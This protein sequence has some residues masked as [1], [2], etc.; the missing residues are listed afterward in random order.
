LKSDR[1]EFIKKVGL[2]TAAVAV[3]A[4][5]LEGCTENQKPKKISKVSTTDAMQYDRIV[6]ANDRLRVGVI[7]FSGRFRGS[8]SKAF[9]A[10]SKKLN[11]EFVALSDI[12]N[13]RREDGAAYLTELQGKNVIGYRNNEE[14]YE[15]S[16]TDAVIISTAD[17]QHAYHATEAVL[18][19]RDAYVEKPLAE[20]MADNIMVLNAV[21]E[22]GKIV[23]LGSQRRS[24][25]NYHTAAKY[26]KSGKFGP[27]KVVNMTWNVNQPDRWRHPDTVAGLKEADVDWNRF[28]INKEKIPF[29]PRIYIEYR[30]FWPY[31]SGIPGQ[32]M[33]H[34]IDT[35]HWF[36]GFNHPLSVVANGGIYMWN[37][38]RK[39]P[40]TMT[41]VFEYGPDDDPDP[42]KRFQVNYSSRFSNSAGGVKEIYYSNGGELNLDT[43]KVTSNGGLTAGH[44][45]KFPEFGLK[46]N[47]LEDFELSSRVSKVATDAN[48]GTDSDTVLHMRNWMEC[49]RSRKQT[50]AP[51]EAGFNHSVASLM[52]TESLHRGKKVKFDKV[53]QE[54]M[55]I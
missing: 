1:R 50:N 18:S 41:A 4:S 33:V 15:K 49:L 20:S 32:W 19:G 27:I 35:V 31:S 14:L 9:L 21:K 47:L 3:G 10:S 42:T 12:W 16:E 52:V 23:Q 11:M 17:F 45:E 54:I 36:T 26:I 55:D 48:T 5:I 22:T 40:D 24:G 7:G 38:G 34:Q 43:N 53:N 51:I 30:L 6:G 46:E 28:L 2:G 44:A 13:K 37:D 39:N 8:L 29:D 25:N